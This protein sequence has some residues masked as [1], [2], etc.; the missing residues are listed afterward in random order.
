MYK[1]ANGV[2]ADLI[3]E[4]FQLRKLLLSSEAYIAIYYT[5]NPYCV[6]QTRNCIVSV[7]Q[8]MG[9]C[10]VET[11]QNA[12]K[13]AEVRVVVQKYLLIVPNFVEFLFS[14]LGEDPGSFHS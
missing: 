12:G 2:S 5:P 10:V 8:N 7:I 6:E 9:T 1:V 3:R 14:G 13:Y 11:V 4:I